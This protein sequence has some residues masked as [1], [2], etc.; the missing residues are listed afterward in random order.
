MRGMDLTEAEELVERVRAF[1]GERTPVLASGRAVLAV[2]GGADSAA[3]LALVREAGVVDPAG[4]VAAHFDHGLRGS[5]A[6]AR[7][8]SAVEALCGRYGMALETG[9]WTAPRRG[10]AAARE[11]RYAFLRAVADRR[12]LNAIVT[13]HTADDQ[14]ETV[15]LHAAR[16]A[17]LHGLR[18]MA[19]EAQAGSATVARPLLCV[20]REETRAFCG[21]RAVAF[22]DDET[23]D[24]RA[25]ARNRVRLD[26]LPALEEERPG[27]REA[28][29]R[30]AES[31]REAVAALEEAA[32]R[33]IVGRE[34]ETVVLARRALLEMADELRPYAYRLAIEQALGHARDIERRH[35]AILSRAAAARTGSLFEL[36]HGVTVVVE[37]DAI[38][39]SAGVVEAAAIPEAFEAA[40]PFAGVVGAWRLSVERGGGD[41]AIAM[42]SAAVVRRRRPGDRI[43]LRGGTRKLQDVFVDR[44][45]PRRERDAVPVIAAGGDVLWTPFVAGVG[46]AAGELFVIEAARV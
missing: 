37:H 14:A 34:G 12:G 7:D 11:A 27:A 30:L 26:V 25:L 8:L 18:G 16:G 21:L 44:K 13:G 31:A 41:H 35:Y 45:V 38:V 42:P 17:G 46:V 40:V 1:A 19:A 36:P 22:A 28:V 4:S 15:V 43:L 39:V 5:E 6:A 24:D 29:L 3:M 2:S 10:E 23:N 32:A 20:T 9:T 33:A